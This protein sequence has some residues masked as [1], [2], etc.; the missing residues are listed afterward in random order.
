MV[1]SNNAYAFDALLSG[2][3]FSGSNFQLSMFGNTSGDQRHERLTALRQCLPAIDEVLRLKAL[4]FM[5]AAP[6]CV[7]RLYPKS[8]PPLMPPIYQKLSFVERRLRPDRF[9]GVSTVTLD[10]IDS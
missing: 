9:C 4:F 1:T 10:I 3:G 5:H 7:Q 2:T 6:L 8:S